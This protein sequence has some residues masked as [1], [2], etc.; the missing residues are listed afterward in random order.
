MSAPQADDPPDSGFLTGYYEPLVEGSLVPGP[1]FTAPIL[2]RPDDLVSFPPGE[3]PFPDHPELSA[4]RQRPD[5][6]L[7][8][9]PD[10]AAIEAGALGSHTQPRR[11]AA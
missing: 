3:L 5:F 4:G 2:A 8:P 11:L 9:Y 7:E 1:E 6:G 10:R